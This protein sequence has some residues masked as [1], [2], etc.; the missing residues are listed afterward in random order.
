MKD[1]FEIKDNIFSAPYKSI[2]KCGIPSEESIEVSISIPVYN[3][4]NYFVRALNS[5][6][7]QTYKEKY[8]IIVVDNNFEEDLN[9]V[10]KYEQFIIGLN[11]DKILY[12]KNEKNM[13]PIYNFNQA[14]YLSNSEYFVM[15]HEDDELSEDCLEKLIEFKNKHSVSNELILTSNTIID[16]KSQIKN[17]IF[18]KKSP[19][20]KGNIRKLHLWDFFLSS[21]SNGCGCL[22]NRRAFVEI[23]GYN[24]DYRPSAD[25]AML[26]LYVYKYGGFLICN[27][28]LYRY[29]ITN[30]NASNKVFYT[31][32]ER[33]EFYRNCMKR[34]IRI[35][36]FILD[37]IIKANKACHTEFAEKIWLGNILHPAPL[38]EKIIMEII[39]KLNNLR[40]I[41]G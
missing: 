12:Y 37:R 1:L 10:N 6:I 41:I 5:A 22:I 28:N 15:C 11:C 32:I 33:D 2:L 31:C 40:H 14:A 39:S 17:S 26:S 19:L 21:P 9:V 16:E 25:Y 24:P 38:K 3:S 18:N 20:C 13:G 29:R 7:H 30:Q 8:S 35:P 34:K 27:E 4:F 23:G 36:N